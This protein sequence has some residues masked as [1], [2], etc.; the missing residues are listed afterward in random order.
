MTI[1]LP[2]APL[3][4]LAASCVLQDR[5]GCLP[6]VPLCTYHQT[7][8]TVPFTVVYLC[9][10]SAVL[11][12]LET[13]FDPSKKVMTQWFQW[14][15]NTSVSETNSTGRQPL[16]GKHKTEQDESSELQV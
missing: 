12:F 13:Q 6:A 16:A 7:A 1:T 10:P 15:K 11:N 4:T 2:K 3:V 5:V 8:W 14:T 9:A